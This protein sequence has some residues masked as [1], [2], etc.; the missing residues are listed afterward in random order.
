MAQ[1]KTDL[2]TYIKLLI[3][4]KFKEAHLSGGRTATWGSQEHITDLEKQIEEISRRKLRE[5]IGSAKRSEWA[6]VE[7]RLKAELRSAKRSAILQE[8]DE[9]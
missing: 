4:T 6:K 1:F 8:K 5:R 3:E 7:S 2:K 9:V